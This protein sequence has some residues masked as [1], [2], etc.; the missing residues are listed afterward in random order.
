MINAKF[1]KVSVDVILQPL[2]NIINQCILQ[3]HFPKSLKKVIVSPIYKKK[4]PF[5]KENY[6]PISLLTAFSRVF[7]KEI[8]LQLSPIL[9]ENGFNLPMCL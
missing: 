2:L 5:N 3:G 7:E 8:E 6:R 9:E 4:D 1:L